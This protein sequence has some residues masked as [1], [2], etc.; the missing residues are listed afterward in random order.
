MLACAGPAWGTVE[1][2]PVPVLSRGGLAC[3]SPNFTP[4]AAGQGRPG[5]GSRWLLLGHWLITQSDRAAV[6]TGPASGSTY[7][8]QSKPAPP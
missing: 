4:L 2:F 1:G 8:S 7:L 3:S 6:V 5:Q